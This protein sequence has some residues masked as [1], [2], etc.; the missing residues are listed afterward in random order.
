MSNLTEPSFILAAPD[1][2]LSDWLIRCE[3][4][5]AQ[6]R[7]VGVEVRGQISHLLIP[8]KIRGGLGRMLSG[9]IQLT[10]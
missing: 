4:R 7:L 2:K 1:A 3:M 9:M 6:R 5:A 8:V 10:L